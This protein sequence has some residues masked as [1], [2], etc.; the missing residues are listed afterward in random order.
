MAGKRRLALGAMILALAG[1]GAAALGAATAAKSP[2][3]VDA[4]RLLTADKDGDNWVQDGRT[5]SA[6][7]YSPRTQIN[8][9]NVG[10]LGLAWSAELDTYRGVEGTPLFIDG[11]IYNTSAWNIVT[12]Y[13]A[14]TGKA[15]WT[16]DPQA[17][18][19]RGRS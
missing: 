14:R 6:Q 17:P 12:A 13:D 10:K 7:R 5:Y 19:E 4:Q 9:G 16:Y 11:V 8:A 1:M 18:R 15:L 3:G 2:A